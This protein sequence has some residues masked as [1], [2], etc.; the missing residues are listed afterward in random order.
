METSIAELRDLIKELVIAQKV[1]DDKFKETDA[2]FKETAASF[3]E[4]DAQ[5]KETDKRIKAAFELFEGQWGKLIESLVEGDLIRLLNDRGI[6]VNRTSMRVKGNHQGENFEFDIIAH[7]GNEIVIVEVKTSLRVSYV[8]KF[9]AKLK[10]VKI[11]L[12]EYKNYTIYGAMAFLQAQEHS[13]IY[14]MEPLHG[15]EQEALVW[16]VISA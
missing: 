5:F 11:G 1:T 9:I 3:K 15:F 6:K 10:K 7:N 16:M 13:D 4:T 8:K 14:A 2:K 12:P